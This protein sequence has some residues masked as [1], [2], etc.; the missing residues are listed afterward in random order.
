MKSA[1]S[2]RARVVRSTLYLLAATFALVPAALAN[3]TLS[4]SYDAQGRLVRV[5]HSGTVNGSTRACYAYDQAD[6]RTNVTVS[7]T[8]ECGGSG[9]GVSFSVTDATVTEGGNLVFTVQKSGTAPGSVSIDYSSADGTAAAGSDY[10]AA[11][12]TLTFLAADTSKTVS[13]GTIDDA[14]KESAETLFLNL[15]N[16]T[17]GATVADGQGVGT[18]NDNDDCTGVSFTIASNGAVTEGANSVFTITKSGTTSASSCAVN[19]ATA[20]GTG[21]SAAIAPGDYTATSGTLTF[22]SA[23]TSKTVSVATV[24]DTSPEI[25]E[26]FSMALSSPTNGA[27]LGTPSSASATINDDDQCRGI[28]FTIASN[29][30]VTEGTSSN[31]TV[32]KAGTGQVG[33]CTVNYATSNGSAVAP[34]DYTAT[35]GTLS[36]TSGQTTQSVSVPTIADGLTE[37]VETFSMGLSAPGNGGALGTPSSATA[38]INNSGGVCS[39]VS[40]AVSD[41]SATEGDPLIFTVTKTGSTSSSCSIS[42][43]TA[44]GTATAPTYYTA[45]SGTL[46]FSSSQTSQTVSVTTFDLGRLNATRRMFLNLSNATAGAAISDAQ[47]IGSIAASGGTCL[48]CTQVVDPG[49]TAPATGSTTTT[50]DPTATDPP[51]P[52]E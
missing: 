26:T 10:T 32:T 49:A 36:F 50:S 3:E 22:T 28:S 27:A 40:F 37:G 18:I 29:G 52:G 1:T 11:S 8:A 16:V 6:N 30:A 33:S 19:Y 51:P 21:A 47:G 44:D 2:L 48:T 35:S 34:G 25:T 43:A 13:V 4:Y 20:D 23:Q 31:F 14:T 38:T 17:A 7:T 39:S 41:A 46:T 15:F 45:K 9:I 5:A 42:Y 12:G 24:N